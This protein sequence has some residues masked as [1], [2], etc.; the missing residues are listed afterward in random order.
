MVSYNY[1]RILINF[2]LLLYLQSDYEIVFA[3]D[4][5]YVLF[6]YVLT[7]SIHFGA[8][9]INSQLA[10]CIS[11]MSWYCGLIIT[12]AKDHPKINYPIAF[13]GLLSKTRQLEED[14]VKILSKMI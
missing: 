5:F 2:H 1:F 7:N 14:H 11:S 9:L 13:H 6:N 3:I 12:D 8:R 4:H 10:I